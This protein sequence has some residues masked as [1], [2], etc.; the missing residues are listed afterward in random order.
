MCT[1]VSNSI[2]V[3]QGNN[4]GP[5]FFLIFYSDLLFL[6]DCDAEVY[7]DDSTLSET[8]ASVR[9]IGEK[10][11]SNCEKVVGWMASNKLK[12]NADKTHL[13]KVGTKQRIQLTE[14][15]KVDMDE[16]A[17]TESKEKC[18]LLL[19]VQIQSD[20]KWH[21][22]VKEL[23][24]KLRKRLAG[25]RKLKYLVPY[26]IRKMICQGIF[27]SVLV[28]CL[29]L[30]GGCNVGELKNLQTLQNEA[31]RIVTHSGRSTSRITLFNQLGWMTVNQLIAYHTLLNVFKIRKCAEPEYLARIL[32]NDNITGKINIPNPKLTLV[33]NSFCYRG[34]VDWNLLPESVRRSA[35]IGEFKRGARKWVFETIPRFPD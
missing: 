29:P 34:A 26:P 27:N 22:Q 28:Y 3:S 6:L 23:V 1:I 11:S 12:L 10:L 25:L 19:G 32:Q 33:K 31:A 4:L 18:E 7:A 9:E 30:F 24:G 21:V 15:L 35:K 5:L 16:V 2:G 13:L 8:G 14:D 17:L 20:L